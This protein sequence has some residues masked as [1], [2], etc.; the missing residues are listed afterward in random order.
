MGTVQAKGLP[1]IAKAL[2]VARKCHYFWP[3]KNY[4]LAFFAFFGAAF[5]LTG[6]D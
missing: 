4:F 5:F 1:L 3:S 6:I 2:L